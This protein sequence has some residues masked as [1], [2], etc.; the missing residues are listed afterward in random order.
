MLKSKC[1][2]SA[3][4]IVGNGNFARSRFLLAAG[5]DL[6]ESVSTEE[7]KQ[8]MQQAKSLSRVIIAGF[9]PLWVSLLI[10][11]CS[12]EG[13]KTVTTT[14]VTTQHTT[15]PAPVVE[16][17]PAAPVAP[18]ETAATP[19]NPSTTAVAPPVRIDAGS[20]SSFTDSE[21]HVWLP[22]QGFP[23]GDMADRPDDMQI[24]NTSDPA[25][26]RTEHYGM[27]SFS[28]P[29]PNG[30]YVVKLHFAET[31]DGITGPGGR[32]FTVNVQGQ[33]FKDFDIWVK[34][35]GPQHAYVLPVNIEVTDGKV[36]ITFTAQE[37]NPE[38]NGIEILP[39]E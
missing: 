1:K 20:S 8:L 3:A 17:P 7:I 34:A 26:Y 31:Y 16:T 38:I 25:L 2:I 13:T 28:Y 12:S 18:P 29:V 32:V 24:A 4:E 35:G 27:S 15:T 11:G 33:E 30:K 21:G 39:A 5:Q 14:T 36:N 37:E 22:D 6:A 23:D 19:A 10:V 9:I